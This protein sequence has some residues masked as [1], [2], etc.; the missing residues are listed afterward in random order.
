[1]RN[2]YE[3]E[4]L[5]LAHVRAH[6]PAVHLIA[7]VADAAAVR[8]NA[9]FVIAEGVAGAA[10]GAVFVCPHPDFNG[11]E[12]VDHSSDGGCE[13]SEQRWLLLVATKNA[14]SVENAYNDQSANARQSNGPLAAEVI[15]AMTIFGWSPA[16][17]PSGRPRLRAT[18][19][20]TGMPANVY[21]NENGLYITALAYRTEQP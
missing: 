21:P 14:R 9:K 18:R 19:I 8:E 15:N 10:H 20:P 11:I 3:L 2:L 6:C 4:P 16:D 7:G 17:W 5:L 1:M 13:I 12:R